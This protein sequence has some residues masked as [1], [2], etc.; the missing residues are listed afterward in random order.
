MKAKISKTAAL[1][2]AQNAV[3]RPVGHGT[4]WCFYG[5]YRV[6]DPYGPITEVRANSYTKIVQK[7][8]NCVASVAIAMM[9]VAEGADFYPVDYVENMHGPMSAPAFVDAVMKLDPEHFK[10]PEVEWDDAWVS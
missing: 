4:N 5:P 6:S 8:A 1:R 7:R 3:G 10:A 9:G 2:A